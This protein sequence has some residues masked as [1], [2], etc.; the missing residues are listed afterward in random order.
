MGCCGGP[1]QCESFDSDHE[2]LSEA[3]LARF[4]GDEAVCRSCGSDYYADASICPN[5]GEA[6]LADDDEGGF[7][8]GIGF[9]LVVVGML[10]L[11]LVLVLL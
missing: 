7:M 3:D 11:M 2:G 8:K 6:V 10:G 9:P 1:Q 4:G 5:C